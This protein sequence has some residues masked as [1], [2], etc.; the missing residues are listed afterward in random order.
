VGDA[1]LRELLR[2]WQASGSSDDEAALLLARLRQRVVSREALLLCAELGHEGARRAAQLAPPELGLVDANTR[3]RLPDKR[4]LM[5][6]LRDHSPEAAVRF[7]VAV[8]R[9]RL[10]A[11]PAGPVLLETIQAAE[12]W[13]A[14]PC[15]EHG[16]VALAL[17]AA[18]W[19]RLASGE[20]MGRPAEAREAAYAT[21]VTALALEP[22]DQPRTTS[23]LNLLAHEK[24]GDMDAGMRELTAWALAHGDPVRRRVEA[25]QREAGSGEAGDAEPTS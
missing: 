24:A 17:G 15:A 2:R 7:G 1:R 13:A 8:S 14:C 11:W 16:G 25:R 20:W 21:A 5:G 23:F 19:E 12:R 10:P 18:V 6:A 3:A 22:D 4:K 9:N